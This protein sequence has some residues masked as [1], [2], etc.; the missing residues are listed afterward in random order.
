MAKKYTFEEA[1][2]IIT[3]QS[4]CKVLSDPADFRGVTSKLRLLC[5][6]GSEFLV[7]LHHFRTQRQHQC[8]KCGLQKNADRCRMT[9]DEI[10]RRLRAKGC[11][12]VSGEYV[13]QRS[14]ITV[15]CVCGHRRTSAADF[16]TG[17]RFSGLCVKCAIEQQHESRR[18]TT[19][20]VSVLLESKGLVLLSEY[21]SSHS[22]IRLRCSCGREFTST[23]GL[24]RNDNKRACCNF[25]SGR[26]SRGEAAISNWLDAHG[27]EYER[28]KS[29]T[30]LGAGRRKL[31]FDF[32][33][34]GRGLCIEFDGVGHFEPVNFAGAYDEEGAI[35]RLASAQERDFAKDRF[36]AD[37]GID[38]LRI[39]YTEFDQIPQLLSDKLIPR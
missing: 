38:L 23:Y 13:N 31:R 6:C 14:K 3:E 26:V 11:E 30:G 15:L 33:I 36:C 37:S 10:H 1:K 24:I 21:V 9:L 2:Q 4:D 28:E 20:E 39:S 17:P 25:C 35:K 34:P 22:H 8:P 12:Y 18:L 7:D 19:E 32:Y 16:L 27:L 5:P 29:F